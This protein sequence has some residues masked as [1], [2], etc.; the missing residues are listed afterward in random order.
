MP[1]VRCIHRKC[2]GA[3][4]VVGL[5]GP[6]DVAMKLAVRSKD[7]SVSDT[8]HEIVT[9]QNAVGCILVSILLHINRIDMDAP[10]QFE[11]YRFEI[12]QLAMA[13]PRI[14]SGPY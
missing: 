14:L 8:I 10:C 3:C 7:E 1:I 9:S 11:P 4:A 5:D 6:E 2:E 12:S 13:S